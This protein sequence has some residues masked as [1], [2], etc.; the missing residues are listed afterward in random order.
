[1]P[2]ASRAGCLAY[3]RH[4]RIGEAQRVLLVERIADIFHVT[5]VRVLTIAVH[6]RN[7]DGGMLVMQPEGRGAHSNIQ[8]HFDPGR[9]QLDP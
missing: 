6:I 7:I 2:K 5:V 8:D 9:L 1:M 3:C 4:E